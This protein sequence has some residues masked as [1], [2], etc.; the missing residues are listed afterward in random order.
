V[1]DNETYRKAFDDTSFINNVAY[2]SAFIPAG[3]A[4]GTHTEAGL[5]IDGTGTVDTGQIISRVLFSPPITKSALVSLT[6]EA[7]LTVSISHAPLYRS[8]RGA[9]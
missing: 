5:F 9:S 4:T 1:L 7:T 8:L 2:L 6:I 3:T